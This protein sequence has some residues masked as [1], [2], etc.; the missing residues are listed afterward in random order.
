MKPQ[1]AAAAILAGLALVVF[2]LVEQGKSN[3]PGCALSTA[4]A[5]ALV[6]GVTEGKDTSA[7]V[8]RSTVAALVPLACEPVVKRLKDESAKPVKLEIP[9][10]TQSITGSQL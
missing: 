1:Y 7:I 4:A 6:T 9:G 8:G 3:T 10:A 2:V 5:V